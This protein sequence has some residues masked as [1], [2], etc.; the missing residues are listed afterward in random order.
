[1]CAGDSLGQTYD[2]AMSSDYAVRMRAYAA[3]HLP[4]DETMTVTW[5]D[6]EAKIQSEYTGGADG[7]AYGV[8]IHG[9]IR[10]AGESLEGAEPRLSTALGDVLPLIALSANAAVADPLMVASHGLDL[11]SPQ[12]FVG[13]RTPSAW[14]WFP[15][16]RRLIDTDATLELMTAIGNHPQADLLIR[17]VESY[18]RALQ[19]WI[20]E[21]R[22]MAGEFLFIAAETLSRFLL[23]SRAQ[24]R[25]M[26]PKNLARLRG[27][28]SQ[29]DLRRRYLTDE[30]FGTDNDAFEAT[31]AASNGF[32]H[33]YMAVGDVRGLLEPVLERSMGLVRR[34]LITEAGLPD[35][36]RD[37]LL[38]DEYEEPRGLV[39][40]IAF[41][42]G[43]LER[44]DAQLPAP[45][46][47]GADIEL[48]W[49]NDRPIAERSED[50]EV[51]ISFPFEITYAKLP[52]NTHVRSDGFGMRAAHFKRSD[53]APLEVSVRRAAD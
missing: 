37:R 13:Y 36:A 45:E 5:T 11:N 10:G 24:S 44:V 34:A 33:G 38:A 28:S 30:I 40:M 9:E 26:T 32:E 3:A 27:A 47:P 53:N 23:E 51:S 21:Q 46:M 4:W 8:T 25:G 16:G 35:A 2:E 52:E 14:E 7:H 12:P 6:A 29:D 41:V 43:K 15:Q 42:R 49:S 1:M 19:H 50:G 31:E 17:A 48:E 22:L 39:P 20:P 18:R